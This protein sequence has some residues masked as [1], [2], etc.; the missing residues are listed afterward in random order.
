MDKVS[1]SRTTCPKYGQSVCLEHRQ[2]VQVQSRFDTLFQVSTNDDYSEG[3]F[4][5]FRAKAA[6]A[7]T[8]LWLFVDFITPKCE[9]FYAKIQVDTLPQ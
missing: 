5:T 7:S 3:N 2:R 4:L 8:Y 6:C 1:R 9:F